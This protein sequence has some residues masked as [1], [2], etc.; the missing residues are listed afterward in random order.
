MYMLMFG[1]QV[2]LLLRLVPGNLLYLLMIILCMLG[3]TFSSIRTRYLVF[4]KCWKSMFENRTG[5]TFKTIRSNKRI[6]FTE[7]EL[8]KFY[9]R[10]GVVRHWIVK[11]MPQQN[12]VM[13]IPNCTLLQKASV[14]TLILGYIEN[15]GDTLYSVLS[16]EHVDYDILKIF[17]CTSY[18]HIKDSKIDNIAKKVI[19][20]EYAKGVKDYHLWS[21]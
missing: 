9:E 8:K 18:Y 13:E 14:Y 6:K 2:K 10:E 7:G 1:I 11:D 12:G 3:F 16:G 19:L 15:N 21:V 4:F 17:G 5:R 20:L